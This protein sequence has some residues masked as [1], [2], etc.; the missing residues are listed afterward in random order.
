M[1]QTL[2]EQEE[3]IDAMKEQKEKAEKRMRREEPDDEFQRDPY[4]NLNVKK[5]RMP[6]QVPNVY[7]PLNTSAY[8]QQVR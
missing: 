4:I 6:Y 5:E 2:K 7:K 8:I 3:I 1:G